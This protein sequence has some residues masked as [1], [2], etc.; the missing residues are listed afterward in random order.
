MFTIFAF[1]RENNLE[2][3]MIENL[4]LKKEGEL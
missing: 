1:L 3:A 2:L 4:Y